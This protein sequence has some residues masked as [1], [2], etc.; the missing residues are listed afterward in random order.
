MK[1]IIAILGVGILSGCAGTATV[2]SCAA[3]LD[4]VPKKESVTLAYTATISYEGQ[5]FV[6]TE[7]I[8]CEYISRSCKG[9]DWSMEWKQS[10]SEYINFALTDTFRADVEVPSCS[11]ALNALSA[12]DVG[13]EAEYDGNRTVVNVSGSKFWLYNNYLLK[14]E[15]S[16]VFKLSLKSLKLKEA[17]D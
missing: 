17:G 10:S 7:N 8:S 1:I 6:N 4:Q 11:M 14:N 9:G 15:A 2:I 13:H 16:S 5:E 3:N 12:S